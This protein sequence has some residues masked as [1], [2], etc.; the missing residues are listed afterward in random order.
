MIF[1]K[2]INRY[3]LKY[4]GWLLLGVVSLFAVDSCQMIIPKLYR[5]IING[6]NTGMVEI[7]GASV[8]FGMD[9]LLDKV[10]F[11]CWASS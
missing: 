8:A 5:I 3:Y 7:D 6:L 2:H 9:I 10:C 11:P 1:G 4:M